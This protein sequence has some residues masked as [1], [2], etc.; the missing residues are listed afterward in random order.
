MRLRYLQEWF[1]NNPAG[2]IHWI[3]RTLCH[4]VFTAIVFNNFLPFI[5]GFSFLGIMTN[6]LQLGL[7]FTV[8]YFLVTVSAVITIPLY[9]LCITALIYLGCDLPIIGLALAPLMTALAKF[10]SAIRPKKQSDN[11]FATFSSRSKFARAYWLV[12]LALMLLFNAVSVRIVADFYPNLLLVEGWTTILIVA[13]VL[14]L[15]NY[16]F[17]RLLYLLTKESTNEWVLI[18]GW[19]F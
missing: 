1:T 7:I 10:I 4:V 9:L 3:A 8:V 12:G 2:W 19:I 17:G 14:T 15:S 5:P 16:L 18:I 13:S 6:A 11:G